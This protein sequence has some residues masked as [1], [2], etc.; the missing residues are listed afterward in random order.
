MALG[1]L[2]IRTLAPAVLCALAIAACG[3]QQKP[4][5]TTTTSA[6]PPKHDNHTV[7][8]YSSL[9]HSG[10]QRSES[11]QIQRG[12]EL[13]LNPVEGRSYHGFRIHYKSL[14]DSSPLARR[15]HRAVT[16]PS[17][18]DK[19]SSAVTT[20]TTT[21]IDGWNP[22]ATVR[23]AERA[24][25][26]A[27]TITY[28]G[29]LDSGATALSLP[30]LNQAG[31]LQITPGSGYP[32][33]TDS[34]KGVTSAL[35]PHKYYPQSPHTLLRLIP[36]DIVE[37]SAAIQWLHSNGC[38][39]LSA[40]EFGGST[41]SAESAALLKAIV[42][43]AKLY[44]GMTYVATPS[45]CTDTKSYYT[46]VTKSLQPAG[47][48]CGILVGHVTHAAAVFTADLRELLGPSPT[49]VG[50]SRFCNPGW[51]RA[52]FKSETSKT[53]A[54][55]VV[56]SLYCMTPARPVKSYVGSRGS[57]G[58]IANYM[59]AYHQRPTAYG[60]YG[61]MAAKMVLRAL[62]DV[63]SEQDNRAQVRSNMLDGYS[64][65]AVGAFSFD[66]TGNVESNA[67]AVDVFSH[68][69]PIWHRTVTP[70]DLY[71]LSSAG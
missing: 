71:L 26:N 17:M 21:N 53:I 41:E 15:R 9:P 14:D 19:S 30:I 22:A 23:N 13:V 52:I 56:A 62:R 10:P 1:N 54:K 49:I 37:A 69:V 68:G 20:T 42:A 6:K 64:P 67:Y 12:I 3:S 60:Y 44:N 47:L 28:I 63:G 24:A 51:S 16:S 2:L 65:Y 57:T 40:W 43:T 58:V 25:R 46:F 27:Q 11:L 39:R 38:R 48:R 66:A 32:G 33:L 29:D 18:R 50:T 70:G 59:Q 7:W 5:D 8:I 35:E 61:Y 45:P 55:N 4:V 31:I 36:N 34:Y